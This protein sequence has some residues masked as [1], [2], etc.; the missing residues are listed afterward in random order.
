MT[1]KKVKS[2]NKN[3]FRNQ[4][5]LKVINITASKLKK[6]GKYAFKGIDKNAVFKIT[7]SDKDF[8]RV[9]NLI[10]KSGVSSTVTFKQ[11]K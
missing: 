7:G 9:K 1:G 3:A 2:I 10:I 4:K 6:V 5:K 11:I 8:E